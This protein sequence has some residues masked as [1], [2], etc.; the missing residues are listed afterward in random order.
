MEKMERELAVAK[1]A[2][3]ASNTKINVAEDETKL[4]DLQPTCL[5]PIDFEVEE[6]D[7]ED[8]RQGKQKIFN[9]VHV[10]KNQ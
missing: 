1:A 5:S 10:F 2:E 9:I 6:E 4:S 7:D 8:T 3:K